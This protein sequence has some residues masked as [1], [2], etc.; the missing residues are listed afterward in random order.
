MTATPAVSPRSRPPRARRVTE[1]F[2][3]YGFIAVPMLLFLIFNILSLGYA[4][5]ISLWKWGILGPIAFRGLRNYQEIATDPIFAKA[6]TNSIVY[7]IIVV[8]CQMALGL[9]LAVVVNA[10]IRGRTFFRASFYFPAIMSSAAIT[11]LWLFIVSPDG[12][13]NHVRSALGLDPL[14]QA[15]GFGPGWDWI[16]QVQTALAS[17]MVLNIW[18]TSGTIMLFYLASLQ[19]IPGELYEAAA[20]DGANPWQTFW[21]V[22]FPLLRPGHYFVAA[23]SVI[24]ALQMFDQA[25]IAGGSVGA[26]DN[27]LMTIVLYLYNAGFVQFNL[28]YAAAVG[29]VL[30]LV[31]FAATLVQRRLLGGEAAW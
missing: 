13:F 5:Y 19:S 2:A 15:F 31:I 25:V 12:L 29:I 1:A 14:F 17:V 4:F 24:G 27:A 18:T 20:I 10:K 21:R 3:G 30:F 11:V 28:S 7:T 26:P 8:P 16:G 22:T 9:L 6:I 23:V